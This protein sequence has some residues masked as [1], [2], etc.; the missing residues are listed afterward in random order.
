MIFLSEPTDDLQI[1]T[2]NGWQIATK[3]AQ[4]GG[5]LAWTSPGRSPLSIHL[6]DTMFF[7]FGDTRELAI[8]R[9]IK[10]DPEIGRTRLAGWFLRLRRRFSFS[11]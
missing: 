11:R 9:M 2:R 8:A 4:H 6:R 3:P 1:I 10:D 5:F 7:A